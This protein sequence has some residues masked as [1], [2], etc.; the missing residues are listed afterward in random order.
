MN[1]EPIQMMLPLPSSIFPMPSSLKQSIPPSLCPGLTPYLPHL[2]FISSHFTPPIVLAAP[3]SPERIPVVTSSLMIIGSHKEVTNGS[4]ISSPPPS[5]SPSSLDLLVAKTIDTVRDS[6]IPSPIL[7]QPCFPSTND[8]S[9]LLMSEEEIDIFE[10]RLASLFDM[11]SSTQSASSEA[12]PLVLIDSLLEIF[13]SSSAVSRVSL[14]PVDLGVCLELLTSFSRIPFEALQRPIIKNGF[15][16][17][18][19]ALEH[20]NIV[21]SS[22]LTQAIATIDF[23]INIC[24]MAKAAEERL[25]KDKEFVSHIHA[26]IF[27]LKGQYSDAS[28]FQTQILEKKARLEKELAEVNLA[29]DRTT[30]KLQITN[31]GLADRRQDMARAIQ[32]FPTLRSRE[33]IVREQLKH[34]TD[35]WANLWLHVL[36]SL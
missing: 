30:K 5:F 19:K 16:Q 14:P 35:F 3:L 29:L 32:L 33:S 31:Q 11:P 18:Y 24:H 20:S 6:S 21:I 27:E 25:L 26:K 34:C 1:I 36:N 9:T 13:E 15:L 12:K 8:S 10:A 23:Y 22:Q 2:T 7:M 4:P 17:C 28:Q